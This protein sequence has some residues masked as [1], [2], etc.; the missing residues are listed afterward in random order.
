MFQSP[1]IKNEAEV[2]D[3]QRCEGYSFFK[4]AQQI[5]N[6]KANHNKIYC[7]VS[8]AEEILHSVA[9]RESPTPQE[10]ISMTYGMLHEVITL[11]DF[12]ETLSLKG[13]LLDSPV[14]QRRACKFSVRL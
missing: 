2:I 5:V 6:G 3:H 13:N 7:K 11:R 14:I 12:T 10:L 9:F 8:A 4:M 1:G